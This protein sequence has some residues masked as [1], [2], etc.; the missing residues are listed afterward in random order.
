MAGS[1]A[2]EDTMGD[3]VRKYGDYVT[4]TG[5]VSGEEL[6]RLYSKASVLVR[7]G[8]NE[9]GPGLGVLE[10]MG[11]GVPAVVKDGPGSREL[12]RQ[13]ENGYVVRDWEEAAYR[14]NEVLDNPGRI[15]VQASETAKGLSWENHGRRLREALGL[16][17]YLHILNPALQVEGGDRRQH[18]KWDL[19]LVG[20]HCLLEGPYFIFK[21]NPN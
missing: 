11:H 1:W 6:R 14:V 8:F 17:L 15:G 10:A 18:V 5:R 4:V 12:I 20:Y 3:F 21:F 9:R 7:F 2:R 19:E 16:L 13:G